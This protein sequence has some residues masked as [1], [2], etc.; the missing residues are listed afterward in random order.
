MLGNGIIQRVSALV[1]SLNGLSGNVTLAAGSNVTLNTTGNTVTITAAAGSGGGGGTPGGASG[2][3]QFNN[4]GAFGGFDV[5]GDGTLNTGTGELTITKTNSVVFAPSAT[6]DT[7]DAANITSGNL[8]VNR[9]NSGTSASNTTF[10]RG[11]GTWA[12]PAGGGSGSVDSVVAGTNISVDSTDPAN[13]VVSLD[14]N[15]IVNSINTGNYGMS[16]LDGANAFYFTIGVADNF[17]AN[18]S[19]NIIPNDANRTINLSGNLT[20]SSAATISGTNTGD[21]TSVSG[22]AGTATALATGRTISITGDMAY[23]SPSFDGTGNVTAAGTL[24]TVNANTGSFGSSTA[25]P[26]FTVNGKGLITAAGTNVVIAPA[27]TLTGTTLASNVVTSSLTTVGT[28]GTGVWNGTKIAEGFGGTNQSTYTTGDILY[29]SAANTLSK[30]AGNITSTKK[31]LTQTGSGAASAAPGWNTIASGDIPDLS[32]TYQPLDSDLTALAGN[33]TN[34][35]WARTGAGAGAA[36]TLTAG[37]S[38][39]TVS[40]GDGVSGNPTID[41]SGT[42]ILDGIGSTRG[43]V[44]YRGAASWSALTPGTSGQLLSTGGAGA[45]PSWITASG[46]GTV[47]SASVVTANGFQGSVANSTTT[48]AITMQTSLGNGILVSDGSNAIAQNDFLNNNRNFIMN[49]DMR[50]DQAN[51]AA[52]VTLATGTFSYVVDGWKAKFVQSTAAVTAQQV[53]DAPTGFTQSLKVTV[54]TGA[55]VGAGDYIIVEQPIEGYETQ[56]LMYGTANAKTTSLSFWVKSSQASQTFSYALQNSAASRT[57]V[58]SFTV[59]AANT[60]TQ[61]KIPNIVGDTTGTWTTDNTAGLTLIICVASGSTNQTSTLGSWQ[62]ASSFAANTQTSAILAN[63]AA[64][65]QV[66]G[67]YLEPGA[68]C[69]PYPATRYNQELLRCKRYYCKTFS[70]GTKPA[71]SAGVNDSHT[72]VSQAANGFGTAWWFPVEMRAAPTVT[73]YNPSAANA[74]WRDTSNNADRTVN[75]GTPGNR[76]VNIVATTGAAAATNKIHATAD[77][78][79]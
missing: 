28:I 64:T 66:S 11:D 62:A 75:L 74:N 1:L 44:L 24:A 10:W 2:Q 15:P 50:I 51:E 4:A 12:T 59:S 39:I 17:T 57:Y 35:L 33:S 42:A 77:A 27:G 31:F 5:T 23:T 14:S 8:S 70:P 72:Q 68:T 19:L 61:V 60:W 38:K 30:L 47:T 26:N 54:G 22:N 3:V 43:S 65:F 41:A 56:P 29:G 7:T 45:D 21:Q 6:T 73:T 25:I 20:V 16:Q 34:G 78:R 46:T 37:S 52:S 58:N 71:Q 48:P 76:N 40:N 63:S 13:P 69:T 67:V 18:R 36:R 79:L 53:T 49:G 55:T 32:A 9:L